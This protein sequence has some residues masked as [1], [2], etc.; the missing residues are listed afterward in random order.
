MAPSVAWSQSFCLLSPSL[1]MMLPGPSA[2]FE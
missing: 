2:M 1:P